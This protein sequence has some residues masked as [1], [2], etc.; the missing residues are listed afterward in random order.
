MKISFDEWLKTVDKY[1]REGW[2]EEQDKFIRYC[3]NS[4]SP[5]PFSKMVGLFKERWNKKIARSSIRERW[6]KIKN[7]K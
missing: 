4:S 6:E 5:V 1:R 2:T 7:G 3:R